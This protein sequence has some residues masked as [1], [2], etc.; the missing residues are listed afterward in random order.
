L[1]TLIDSAQLESHEQLQ[2]DY[3]SKMISYCQK[4]KVPTVFQTTQK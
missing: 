4:C 1:L 2:V 3:R